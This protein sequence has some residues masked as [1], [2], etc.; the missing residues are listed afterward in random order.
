MKK[1]PHCAEEIQD[2]A[3]ICKY[4]KRRVNI[5]W[6]RVIIVCFIIEGLAAFLFIYKDVPR[7][8]ASRVI[9]FFN[10]VTDFFKLLKELIKEVASAIPAMRNYKD[11]IDHVDKYLYQQVPQTQA[12]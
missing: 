5:S 7:M 10:E 8:L 1:C 9:F 3:V 12:Q 6:F 11:R 2:K 4:C